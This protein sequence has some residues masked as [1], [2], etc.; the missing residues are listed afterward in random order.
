M[1]EEKRSWHAHVITARR[2][3]ESQFTELQDVSSAAW[4]S[5]SEAAAFVAG[6][7]A[8]QLRQQYQP[9]LAGNSVWVI[10][11]AV[12]FNIEIANVEEGRSL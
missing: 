8:R 7:I 12:H 4:E 2:L 3:T 1:K 11:E 6:V 10:P 9:P 5:Q